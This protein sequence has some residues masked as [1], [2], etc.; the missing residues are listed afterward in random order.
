MPRAVFIGFYPAPCCRTAPLYTFLR[1]DAP[2][3]D[4]VQYLEEEE[5]GLS[6]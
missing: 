4:Y 2:E 5:E 3:W 6:R 1:E